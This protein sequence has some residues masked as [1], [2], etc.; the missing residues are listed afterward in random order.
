[1]TV[2]YNHKE[3][4]LAGCKEFLDFRRLLFA[5]KWRVKSPEK[6][7]CHACLVGDSFCEICLML[8]IALLYSKCF[9][10]LAHTHGRR[11]K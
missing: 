11:R 5:C 6:D 3:H 8:A 4:T 7:V 1:M 9:L 10:I 2:V